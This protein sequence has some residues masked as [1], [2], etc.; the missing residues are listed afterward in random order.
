MNLM[1][2]LNA[3]EVFNLALFKTINKKLTGK[4]TWFLDKETTK[5]EKDEEVQAE[6]TSRKPRPDTNTKEERPANLIKTIT[7][8]FVPQTPNGELASRL[9]RAEL[10]LS[11]I[12]GYKVKVAEKSGTNLKRISRQ[13]FQA[14]E[15][16][17][18][19]MCIILYPV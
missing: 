10:E 16:I 11:E 8:I 2:D 15:L 17:A 5:E 19:I 7:V 14:R 13:N 1:T 9:R 3:D 18:A 4:S 12:C 6:T